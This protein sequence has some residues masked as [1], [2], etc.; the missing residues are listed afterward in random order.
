MTC[1]CLP[2]RP[3]KRFISSRQPM[4]QHADRQS[5]QNASSAPAQPSGRL[6]QPEPTHPSCVP[7]MRHTRRTG[8][9][10]PSAGRKSHH[11]QLH[12]E[13]VTSKLSPISHLLGLTR[14]QSPGLQIPNCGSLG[15]CLKTTRAKDNDERRR[16]GRRRAWYEPRMVMHERLG[17]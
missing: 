9:C 15:C 12:S 16:C 8:P 2:G 4:P 14:L 1:S 13:S 5:S 6:S 11:K 17:A 7:E 10:F 3:P